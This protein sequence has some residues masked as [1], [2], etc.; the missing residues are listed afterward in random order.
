MQI[1]YITKRVKLTE[2]VQAYVEKRF[3]TFEKLLGTAS[4][5][6]LCEVEL[7]RSSS[8]KT[9]DVFYAEAN[10][11]TKGALH[12]AT[13]QGETLEAAVDEVKHELQKE[14]RRAK[15]KKETM[16]RKGG[17]EVKKRVRE[18]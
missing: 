8:Q 7:K 18:V 16:E 9:G 11:D 14:L 5:N 4:K 1:T 10:L 3:G 12:R 6:A 2:E 15:R 17:A 13:A